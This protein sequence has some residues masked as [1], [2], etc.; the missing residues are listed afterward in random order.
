ME[1]ELP[2]GA[3]TPFERAEKVTRAQIKLALQLNSEHF[4]GEG[5]EQFG[6]ILQALAQNYHAERLN[7]KAVK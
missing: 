4:A 3:K 7:I 1:Q 6:A 5:L 2:G